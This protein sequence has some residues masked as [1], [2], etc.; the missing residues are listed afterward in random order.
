M[1]LSSVARHCIT[2]CN[3]KHWDLPLPTQ[4]H[5]AA[6]ELSVMHFLVGG[7]LLAG[8]KALCLFAIFHCPWSI[9][10]FEHCEVLTHLCNPLSS[11]KYHLC[12]VKNNN[13]SLIRK[14]ALENCCQLFPT[15]EPQWVLG[16]E[17]FN[18]LSFL[19][20]S[21][22]SK[23]FKRVIQQC[24]LNNWSKIYKW[25]EATQPSLIMD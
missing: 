8:V 10:P 22:S 16:K 6:V 24:H 1:S 21:G 5:A 14:S 25:L 13:I 9:L 20:G 7:R 23:A 12:S 2:S 17:T 18:I 4:L 19:P 15:C 3:F 11:I